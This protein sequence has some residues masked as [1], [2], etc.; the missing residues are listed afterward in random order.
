MAGATTE[1]AVEGSSP[2]SLTYGGREGG[3]EGG[4]SVMDRHRMV[5][6]SLRSKIKGGREGG[7]EEGREERRERQG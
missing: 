5:I 1:T 6:V 2:T 7:R 4:G 3:R